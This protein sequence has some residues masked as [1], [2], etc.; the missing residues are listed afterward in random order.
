M[1][2]LT[3][4]LQSISGAKFGGPGCAVLIYSRITRIGFATDA[5]ILELVDRIPMPTEKA[6]KFTSPVMDPGPI[7]V[8]LEGREV[9]GQGWDIDL[10]ESG[11]W[12]LANLI[13]AQVEWSPAVVSRAETAAQHAA[14]SAADAGASAGRAEKAVTF[15]ESA[16]SDGAKLIRSHVAEDADRA[17]QARQDAETARAG[18]ETAQAGAETA[19]GEAQVAASEAAASA[20]D[21]DTAA[22]A[23]AGSA[24]DAASSA[25]SAATHGDA[26][27]DAAAVAVAAAGTVAQ[28]VGEAVP[29]LNFVPNLWASAEAKS[30]NLAAS[31]NVFPT[32]S[33]NLVSPFIPV[34]PATPYMA[35]VDAG[36]SITVV[37]YDDAQ[38]RIAGGGVV[39]QTG[40]H[41]LV[42]PPAAAFA[43]VGYFA[44]AGG[45]L[46]SVIFNR[47]DVLTNP[48]G[49]IMDSGFWEGRELPPVQSG[50][51]EERLTQLHA[52]VMSEVHQQVVQHFEP[53]VPTI[54]LETVATGFRR[55]RW[56]SQDGLMLWGSY[57]LDL[58]QSAD[59]WQTWTKITTFTQE[60]EAVRELE[61]GEL[62]VS[63]L[64]DRKNGINSKVY[65]SS[66]YDRDNPTAATW[67]EV[68]SAVS[69][70]ADFKSTWGFTV[71][72]NTVTASEYGL[73][74]DEGSRRGWLSEDYG[75][76]WTQVFDIKTVVA[77]GR[78]P[79]TTDAH[80]HGMAWDEY[81]HRLWVVT[82]DSTNT[83]TYYSDDKGSTWRFVPGSNAMQYTGIMPLPD[84]VVFGS[85]RSPNGLH[86]YRRGQKGDAP[87]IE[88]LFLVDDISSL[89]RVFEFPFKRDR[90]PV[91]PTYFSA[92]DAARSHP[93]MIVGFVDGKKGH[94]LW[95]GTKPGSGLPMSGNLIEVLGPTSQGSILAV[96]LLDPTVSGQRILKGT[97]P[98]WQRV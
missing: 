3:G 95:E 4:D 92:S 36:S 38:A 75:A 33:A 65:R 91:T 86:V 56:L 28:L 27:R 84:V 55:P 17:V 51:G 24:S 44:M 5:M 46:G 69:V 20:T 31:G 74:G 43:R 54:T 34:E 70:N 7:R 64:R 81:W 8:E 94:L 12:S 72:G 47:G 29:Y 16:V 85:D 77:E 83:A 49:K 82:G 58:I 61:D 73:R 50:V 30:G 87:T 37:W 98:T 53:S 66:G 89:S 25:T 2:V 35:H 1:T 23:A 62:L 40:T 26:S 48:E 14:V 60:V 13:D 79:W 42:S 63:V 10:P 80:L 97:A 96:M 52:E 90:G 11:T 93:T 21:A 88:P 45:R 6:G 76:T 41:P 68:L 39:E 15:V 71:A 32:G 22:T 57:G 67:T 18:A 59:E 78:P 9:H 19:R